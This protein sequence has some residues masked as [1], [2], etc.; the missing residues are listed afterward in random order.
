MELMR[1]GNTY[2]TVRVASRIN[3]D[4]EKLYPDLYHNIYF[5]RNFIFE[6][7]FPTECVLRTEG[8]VC[9]E[10]VFD[11][12]ADLDSRLKNSAASFDSSSC[13]G[14]RYAGGASTSST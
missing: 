8:D 2:F 12:G 3:K 6:D 13:T 7:P 14:F 11:V 10:F 1:N 9:R 5:N 4:D